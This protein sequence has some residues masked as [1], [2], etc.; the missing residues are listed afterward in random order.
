MAWVQIR[1]VLAVTTLPLLTARA[2]AVVFTRYCLVC[3]AVRAPA[4]TDVLAMT[5]AAPIPTQTHLR[6]LMI[7][8]PWLRCV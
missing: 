3:F 4:G 1:Y 8:I 6:T 5:V 7:S 2:Q